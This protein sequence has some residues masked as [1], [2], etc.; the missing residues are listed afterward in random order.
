MQTSINLSL[1]SAIASIGLTIPAIAVASFWLDGPVVL[2]LGGAEL[3]LLVATAFVTAL[4]FGSGKATVL[5]A[6]Q[7]LALFAT[8]CFLAATP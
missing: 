8:F 7:H 1:G 2:G 4:S 3:A 6:T 5:Q